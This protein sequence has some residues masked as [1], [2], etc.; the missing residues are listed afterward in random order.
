[1]RPGPRSGAIRAWRAPGV[2]GEDAEGP[3]GRRARGDLSPTGQMMKPGSR[4]M[5]VRSEMVA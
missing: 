2:R 4:M 1:M 3:A 5:E